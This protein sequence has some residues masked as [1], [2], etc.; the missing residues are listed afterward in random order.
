MSKRKAPKIGDSAFGWKLGGDFLFVF[1][2]KKIRFLL[3]LVA[4]N[5][6]PPLWKKSE[7][8]GTADKV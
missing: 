2:T 7:S 4:G 5:V 3:Q 8:P 6:D 1:G